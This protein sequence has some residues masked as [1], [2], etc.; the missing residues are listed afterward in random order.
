MLRSVATESADVIHFHGVRQFHLMLGA[1]G[2]VAARSDRPVVAREDGY[3]VVGWFEQRAQCVGLNRTAAVLAANQEGVEDIA[4]R[5]I[6]HDRI[7]LIPNGYNP[8]VF[9]PADRVDPPE[10]GG[11]MRLLAVTR[12]SPEKDPHTLV[13][14]VSR[15]V[16]KGYRVELVFAGRGPIAGEIERHL[17]RSGATYELIGH[18]S[19]EALA[20]LYRTSH[21]FCI[22]SKSEGSNQGVLEAMACGLPVVATDIPGIREVVL[23]AGRLVPP[24]NPFVL[25]SAI[26]QVW[27]DEATWRHY[28]RS[29]LDRSAGLTWDAIAATVDGTYRQVLAKYRE[30]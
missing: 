11:P 12:L 15:L 9:F 1:V 25:A 2:L 30:G 17:A 28:R 14:A 26:E 22:S 24:G 7:A 3:R 18:F 16:S 21:V 29:G 27:T 19:Q 8:E 5:G 4:S 13:D 6:S 23:G 20:Q 10:P